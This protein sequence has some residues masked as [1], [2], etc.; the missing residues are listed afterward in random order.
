MIKS[1]TIDTKP[2][3]T[4]RFGGEE[5]AGVLVRPIHSDAVG[6]SVESGI[7]EV[8]H[9]AAVTPTEGETRPP[10]YL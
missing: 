3:F 8:T 9:A 10:L 5:E 6:H 4:R 7:P 1:C 2:R